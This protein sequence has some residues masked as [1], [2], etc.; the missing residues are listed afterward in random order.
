MAGLTSDQIH[1]SRLGTAV[2]AKTNALIRF[3]RR[4]VETHGHVEDHDLADVREAGFDDAA[5]AEVVAGVALD[6]F[7]NY[8]NIVSDTEVDFPAVPVLSAAS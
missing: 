6:T 4:V 3:A 8:F 2:D 1:D 5:I 7:T